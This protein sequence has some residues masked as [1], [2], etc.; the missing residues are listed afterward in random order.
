MGDIIGHI[1]YPSKSKLGLDLDKRV[2]AGAKIAHSHKAIFH[3]GSFHS[4]CGKNILFLITVNF[5]HN[6]P[7]DVLKKFYSVICKKNRIRF[8]ILD[9]ISSKEYA[10]NHR[11]EY[12]LQDLDYVRVKCSKT[13]NVSKGI[14]RI[15]IWEKVEMKI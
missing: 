5:I 10:Y 6:I 1:C 8:I 9:S 15:E 13:Y 4:V 3:C 12:L 11:G 7:P 2:I 14:R